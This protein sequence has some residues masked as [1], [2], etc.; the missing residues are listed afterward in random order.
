[1]SS[2]AP[3]RFRS[4]LPSPS[5]AARQARA[6]DPYGPGSEEPETIP[7]LGPEVHEVGEV[8]YKSDLVL[9]NGVLRAMLR[10]ILVAKVDELP[11]LL[12]ESRAIL[13]EEA[14]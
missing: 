2:S 3:I 9:E 13:G 11:A 12:A 5:E 10:R 7:P 14:A 1:M 8:E 4:T 6:S